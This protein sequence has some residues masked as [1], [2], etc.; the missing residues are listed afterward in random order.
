MNGS[1]FE[2]GR[3]RRFSRLPR[4]L[5]RLWGP[6]QHLLQ[7]FPPGVRRADRDVDY[8]PP[9][10]AECNYF[11]AITTYSDNYKTQAAIS[12]EINSLPACQQIHRICEIWNSITTLK[13]PAND[14]ILNQ[15]NPARVIIIFLSDSLQY[16]FPTCTCDIS[17]RPC[18]PCFPENP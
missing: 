9:R 15:T 18:P 5:Q 2:S 7:S 6:P 8:S 11:C 14:R 12:S 1:Q 13:D 16:F 3:G 4:R 10:E 17:S